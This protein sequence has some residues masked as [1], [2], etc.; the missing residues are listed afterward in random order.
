VDV[1]WARKLAFQELT[2]NLLEV[3]A[4]QADLSRILGIFC[5]DL[6]HATVS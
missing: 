2:A 5:D 6:L 3:A 4:D 1:G